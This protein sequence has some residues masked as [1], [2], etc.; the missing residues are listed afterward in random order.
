MTKCDMGLPLQMAELRRRPGTVIRDVAHRG[1]RFLIYNNRREM[2]ALVTV[3]D[4][5]AL[6]RAGGQS[7]ERQVQKMLERLGRHDA[8]RQ[9]MQVVERLDGEGRLRP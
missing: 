5:E 6:E 1:Q 2:A 9:V 4:L 7:T 3:R 8:L